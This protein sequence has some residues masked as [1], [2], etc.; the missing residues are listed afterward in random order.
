MSIT[1]A[2]GQ[3]RSGQADFR[4]FWFGQIVSNL[5]S[6]FTVFALPLLVYRI[7]GSA[8]YLGLL[9]AFEWIPLLAFGM[10]IG[11]WIDRVDRRTLMI[12]ADICRGCAIGTIPLL[13]VLHALPIWWIFVVG[14]VN[15]TLWITFSTAEFTAVKNLIPQDALLKANGNLQSSYQAAQVLGPAIAGAAV[16]AG[17]P[18]TAVLAVDA[19]TF[20]VS[21]LSLSAIRAT[22]NSEPPPERKPL[23]LEI[24]AGLRY[25]WA[26]PLLRHISLLAIL[27]NLLG[28]TIWTQL[29]LF[30]RTQ[31]HASDIQIGILFAAGSVGIASLTFATSRLRSRMSFRAAT[32]GAIILYG[33][34]IIVLSVTRIFW[35]AVPIWIIAAG[36]PYSFS[37]HTVALRQA[38][39]P[40][41]L[42]GR[43]MMTAQVFAWSSNP[44]GALLGGLA[45]SASGNVALVFGVLGG[46]IFVSGCAFC[47]TELGRAGAPH[48]RAE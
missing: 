31:L 14:L 4:K 25:T 45:I 33:L 20:F 39:V 23:R 46:L 7:T 2:A 41:Y 5:G 26:R 1:I 47:C 15:G 10:V 44:L 40:D 37:V 35:I 48:L 27:V 30:A 8:I 36:L 34:A 43:V 42:L 3:V 21:S 16:G 12:C 24:T 28:V 22:F 6:S 32:L 17:L 9:T 18:V 11:A 38:T 19:A 29:V 13:T